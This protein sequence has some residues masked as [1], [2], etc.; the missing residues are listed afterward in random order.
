M[1][2][3]ALL[4]PA[5]A[6]CADDPAL[7]LDRVGMEVR[8]DFESG[9]L[10]A[11][12]SY[13]IAEDPGFD[14]EIWCVKEPSFE[15]SAYSL[16]KVVKPNDTDWPRDENLVGMTKKIRLWTTVST[17]LRA[18]VFADGDR[19]PEELRVVLYGSDGK[20]YT[21]SRALPPANQWIPLRLALSGFRAD[22]AALRTGTRLDAITVLIR[23]N[24]VNPHRSYSLCLDDFRLTGERPRR[25]VASEPSSTYLDKFFFTFLNRHF[26]RGESVSLTARP[27][28][29]D[30]AVSLKS[31]VCTV[32]DSRGLVRAARVPLSPSGEKGLWKAAALY[33]IAE[34]DPAGQ[35]TLALEGT[36]TG[37]EKVLDEVR[38]IVTERRMNPE[39]HPRLFFTAD[40][41]AGWKSG[42]MDPKRKGILDAA[43]ASARK[44][45]DRANLDEIVE[46]REITSDFLV[47]GPVSPTWDHYMGWS[48]PGNVM[49]E[50]VTAGA[51]L[52]AFTGDR[53]AGRKAKDAMLR[54]AKFKQWQHPWFLDRHMYT[55]Y[56]V[57]LW[58]YAM[59]IGYD[60][61]YPLFTPE[62]RNLIRA[63]V[64]E[65]A[66]IPHYRD[67]VELNRKPSQV[68][69]HI[70][71]NSTGMI[72]AALAFLGE[73]PS[74]PDLEPYLSGI[75]AKYKA[76]ID[77][78]YRPDGSYAEPEGYA[79]TDTQD[80]TI[81]LDALE[82]NLGID[83]TTTT[84]MK[85]AYRYQLYLGTS[86]G[87]KCPAFGDGGRDWGF[88]LRNLHLWLAHRTK[89]PSA[90][91]RYRW[92]T[93]SGTFSPQYTFFDFLWYPDPELKPKPIAENPPSHWFRSKGNAV[94]RSGWEKDALIFALKLGPH[95]NHYHLDQ[96]TFWLLYNGETLLSEAG[97]VNY[98]TN[99]YYRQFYIQPV[100][101]NT[102]LLNKYPESQ[103]IADMDD[104]VK[105]RNEYP[106]IT[107]CFTGSAVD[108][109][110]GELSCVYKGKLEKYT[111][112]FVYMKPDYLV[113]YDEAASRDPE[114]YS[115]VFNAEGKD[116]F[117]GTGSTV[118]V[119]R[120]NAELRMD[121]LTPEALER[122]VKP[123]PDRDGSLIMLTTPE[124][125]NA[126]RFLAVLI[127]SRE[128]NRADR[129]AWKTSRIGLEG[130]T[131][132]EVLRGG[133][134]D[135]VLFR[136]ATGDGVLSAGEWETDGGRVTVTTGGDGM[137][138]RVWAQGA[139]ALGKAGAEMVWRSGV[140]LSALV[141]YRNGSP[142]AAETESETAAD[143][144]LRVEK[145]PGTVLLNGAKA[146][147]RH[148]RKTGTVTLALPA[149]KNDIR[150]Q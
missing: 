140:R 39:M 24:A 16:C 56:P 27:E 83:W 126:G 3:I 53:E 21:W 34:S 128:D 149:G 105:A 116:A 46:F 136:T 20:R 145:K 85:D 80:L 55:Y 17:E 123:H 125:A 61:C 119:T 93:E 82:R 114:R 76:H 69:N 63:A 101:H 67:W 57:G 96:G 74:N 110:E 92:Q 130:W 134:T 81:C 54:F 40:D 22:G 11:W 25:F 23:Y 75:L 15:G 28:A 89:D 9:E 52:Y 124:R 146:K 118:R 79:G 132:A 141:E 88:A 33:R 148:D 107:S 8:D 12:E 43:L 87:R 109:V 70:G 4:L 44:T 115:W 14:P 137:T 2:L 77:A 98:Y 49:R 150:I 90:L 30:R 147:Y 71:M 106:R 104:E 94:F 86:D 48:R 1:V 144:T 121:I 108:A 29:G 36:G 38:F 62:E 10:N 78:A 64:M 51:F 135:R 97:Y 138:R 37:G 113:M 66:L 13:P 47:G 58:T 41:L 99:L 72:L 117:Q 120:P 95:S 129:T 68:T 112:S 131:G 122:T 26:L 18:A 65:K 127:P 103:R 31:L 100:S 139:T 19:K 42:S 50:A 142:C 59:G 60:L 6:F 84:P 91:E 102:L 5:R 143:F 7:S 45:L 35:W 32:L 133:I 111:R 73:D